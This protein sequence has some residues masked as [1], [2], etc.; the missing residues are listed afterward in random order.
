[1]GLTNRSSIR[2]RPTKSD[3]SKS[4]WERLERQTDAETRQAIQDDPDAA[5]ELGA[6]WFASANIVMPTVKEAISLRLDS[7]VL[8]WFRRQGRGYQTRINAVLRSYVNSKR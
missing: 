2:R 7:D 6:D 8:N 1:M 5:P 3:Q 4:D